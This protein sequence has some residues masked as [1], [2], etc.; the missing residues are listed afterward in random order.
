MRKHRRLVGGRDHDDRPLAAFLP[1]RVLE[2]VAHFAPSLSHQSEH[3]E[4]GAGVTRHHAD[5]GAFPHAAATKDP[6]ALPA[7][8]GEEGIHGANAAADRLTNGDTFERKRGHR[9]QQPV[10]LSP[11]LGLSVEGLATSIHYPSQHVLAYPECR[12]FAPGNH[13]ITVAHPAR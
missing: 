7:A 11:I 13:P 2:E 3:G 4:V 9:I 10:L 6:D 5:Q 1:Q 12:S 8:A